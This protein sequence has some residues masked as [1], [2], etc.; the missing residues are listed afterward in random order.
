MV[1]VV[2]VVVRD[3]RGRAGARVEETGGQKDS[4]SRFAHRVVEEDGRGGGDGGEVDALLLA[5][6]A[7]D[8]HEPR[9]RELQVHRRLPARVQHP[10]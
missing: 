3:L 9:V 4:S 2:V 8:G 6:L 1:V 5:H 7:D 10:A